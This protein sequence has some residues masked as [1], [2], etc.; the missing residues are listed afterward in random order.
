MY[1][2]CVVHEV[3]PRRYFLSSTGF[4][5]IVVREQFGLF[6]DTSTLYYKSHKVR[7]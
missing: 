7:G 1:V 4:C 5:D 3:H 6:N 2:E